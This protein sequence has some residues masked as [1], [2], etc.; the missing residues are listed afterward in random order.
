MTLIDKYIGYIGGVRRYS[1]WTV[2]IYGDVLHNYVRVVHND[3]DV[4][5]AELVSSLNR[6]EIRQ[7]E[8]TLLESGLAASTIGLHLSALSGFCRYLVRNGYLESNPVRLVPK[9]KPEKR[10]PVY[11]RKESMEAYFEK[12]SYILDEE[13]LESFKENW[14]T[15]SGKALYDERL[16]RLIVSLLYGLGIRRAEL[17]ALRVGD[18]DSGRNIVKVT[19]KGDKMR[20]IPLIAL[21]YK[22]ISLYLDAV[23]TVCGGKRSLKEPLLVTYKG[24]SLYPG[25]V[26]RAVKSALAD[27][28]GISGRKSPHVLRHTL[29]TELLNEDTG[30]YSIKELLGHSSLAATQVYTH[31]NIARLKTI[32]KSAHPRA[33]NG[34][35]NGD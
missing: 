28:K 7:Y 13:E 23:E 25:Y 21:L 6:S 15:A 30:I 22:E 19:G 24:K 17:I 12:T 3:E 18:I 26:D 4:S 34:G 9:P 1:A 31:S 32:Y 35:K 10:L 27:V 16:S 33:K 14:N 2:S 5:D 20:E 11:F 8:A 29:A